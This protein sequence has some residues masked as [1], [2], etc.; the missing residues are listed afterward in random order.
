MIF[1]GWGKIPG[2]GSPGIY[3]RKLRRLAQE[4]LPSSYCNR[5]ASYGDDSMTL[6]VGDRNIVDNSACDKDEGGDNVN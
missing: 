6:C 4:C 3:N 1:G 2:S 5:L